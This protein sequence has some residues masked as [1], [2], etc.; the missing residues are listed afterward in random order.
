MKTK[1]Y[2]EEESEI[3]MKNKLKQEVEMNKPNPGDWFPRDW[4][5]FYLHTLE[6]LTLI[7]LYSYLWFKA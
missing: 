6:L 3:N 7:V 4:L 1:I 2:K 5:F